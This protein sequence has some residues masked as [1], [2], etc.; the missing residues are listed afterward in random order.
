M[1]LCVHQCHPAN[2]PVARSLDSVQLGLYL[3][4]YFA[5]AALSLQGKRGKRCG[6]GRV[7]CMLATSISVC[8]KQ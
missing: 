1:I 5:T 8:N 6:L 4:G 7:R 3:H 2:V